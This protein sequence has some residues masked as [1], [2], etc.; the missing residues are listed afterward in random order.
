MANIKSN[1]KIKSNVY[2]LF[3][4]DH[5]EKDAAFVS[6]VFY[7][8]PL[9]KLK[10]LAD[11][12]GVELKLSEVQERVLNGD[13]NI[14]L[15]EISSAQIVD[16]ENISQHSLEL[17]ELLKRGFESERTLIVCADGGY[18]KYV[19]F[20]LHKNNIPNNVLMKELA[21]PARHFADVLWDCSDRVISRY[22]F[23]KRFTARCHSESA[24][25]DEYFDSLCGFTGSTPQDGL[26]ISILAEK[27]TRGEIPDSIFGGSNIN[28]TV[29]AAGEAD[30]KKY[31][32]VYILENGLDKPI[33]TEDNVS[34]ERFRI[35]DCPTVICGGGNSA[36]IIDSTGSHAISVYGEVD[37]LSF[38]CGTVGD[39]V[40]KQAYISQNVRKNDEVR[41]ELSGGVYDV[42]HNGMVIAKMSAAFSEYILGEFGGKKY[43]ERL[44]QS[45]G[46]I[47]V[48]NVITVVSRLSQEEFGESVPPQ[49]RGRNFR[50]GVELGGFA[51]P[52]AR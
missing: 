11:E 23:N 2:R 25:A 7:A 5:P 29:A 19:S 42:V 50:L 10:K 3:D 48:T 26:D 40:R 15:S 30:L 28:I 41:L 4:T 1:I 21:A 22:N 31:D 35:A 24:S 32:K 6:Q 16:A 9:A 18:A 36:V 44:P 13:T 39:A 12:N 33:P 49:F 43:F 52:E 14:K 17:K 20:L 47:I 8:P 27:I 38:V 37:R 46:G 45:L 34:A 51:H